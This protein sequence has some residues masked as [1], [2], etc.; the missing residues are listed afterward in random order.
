MVLELLLFLY[1]LLV[2]VPSSTKCTRDHQVL[3]HKHAY[4][5][6]RCARDE[7]FEIAESEELCRRLWETFRPV[8]LVGCPEGKVRSTRDHMRLAINLDPAGNAARRLLPANG[9]KKKLITVL[10]TYRMQ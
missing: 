1:S 2:N 9:Q 6:F 8:H 10:Y 3:C 7:Y 5:A 4:L